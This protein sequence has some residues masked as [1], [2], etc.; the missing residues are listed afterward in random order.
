MMVRNLRHIGY[1]GLVQVTLGLIL[2]VSPAF[3]QVEETGSL[4]EFLLGVEPNAAYDNWLSHTVEGLARDGGYNDHMPEELDPQ[5]DGFG[6][7]ELIEDEDVDSARA[8]WAAMFTSLWNGEFETLE[9]Q[10]AHAEI[11]YEAVIFNDEETGRTFYMLRELLDMQYV[12]PGNDPGE[13]DDVV[14]SFHHGWGLFI[15]SPE[16]ERPGV[17]TQVVHPNDDYISM[18]I[19]VDL[20]L[21]AD[22]Q[23]LTIHGCGREVEWSG[24]YNNDRSIS[25]PSRNPELPLQYYTQFFLDTTRAAGIHELVIQFHSYDSESHQNQSSVQLSAGTEDIVPN[26]PL[27]DLSNS[28]LDII[29]FTPEIAVNANQVFPNHRLVYVD[30]FYA[31]HRA[32]NFDHQA[33]GREIP[34]DVD[35]PGYGGNE[36]EEIVTDGHNDDASL[37]VWVH[38]ELDELPEAFE[39]ANMTELEVY[40]GTVPPTLENWAGITSYYSALV[41]AFVAYFEDFFENP[42]VTAPTVPPGVH[43]DYTSDTFFDVDWSPSNDPNFGAYEVYYDSI[44]VSLDSPVWSIEDDDDL[45]GQNNSDTKLEGL[46]TNTE[47]FIAVRAIDLFGNVSPLSDP[48]VSGIALDETFPEVYN[49]DQIPDFPAGAWPPLAGV[50]VRSIEPLTL[51]HLESRFGGEVQNEMVME[52]RFGFRED[53]PLSYEALFPEPIEGVTPGTVV[54]Y[55]VRVE[56][57]SFNEHIVFAPEEGWSSFTVLEGNDLFFAGLEMDNGGFVTPGAPFDPIWEWGAVEYGPGAGFDGENAWS[58]HHYEP[59]TEDMLILGENFP[60]IG[61]ESAYLTIKHW[62]NTPLST[63]EP[64]LAIAGG[65]VLISED[66]G[67]DWEELFPLS[68]YPC[69][70]IGDGR[71][72]FGGVSNG[73]EDAHFQLSDYVD[74]EEIRIAFHFSS[75]TNSLDESGWYID[76]IRITPEPPELIAVQNL[77]LSSSNDTSIRLTWQANH[78]D[79]YRIYRGTNAYDRMTFIGETTI[80]FFVDPGIL[81]NNTSNQFYYRVGAVLR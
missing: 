36:Q 75:E 70:F 21:R 3:S 14:G 24:N 2:L 41:D 7:I 28:Y 5:L 45:V 27:R 47:Y 39:D 9:E 69:E 66:G 73:W 52:T 37:D 26:R 61:M 51:V 62:Y 81:N 79:V 77:Q 23:A 71:Y 11:D 31:V 4:R 16:S 59:G 10:I 18:P 8:A 30:E 32:R 43:L 80:P 42:D 60:L 49:L 25:D 50:T 76:N 6:M 78:A 74:E 53:R 55:R 29:N 19:T 38:I 72:C 13:E 58:A 68:D 64:E 54:E 17:M 20:F 22:L 40:S 33:S 65:T 56:E 34:D 48:P 67:E 44:E 46:I 1:L 63:D 35:L 57:E 12:D 15:Y